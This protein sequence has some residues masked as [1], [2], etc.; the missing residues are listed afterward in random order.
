[1]RTSSRDRRATRQDKLARRWQPWQEPKPP[2][3]PIPT[4]KKMG[5]NPRQG[6]P[7]DS[8]QC[9]KLEPSQVCPD[10]GLTE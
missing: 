9:D 3:D 1:M 6:R 8:R 10:K 7:I 4:G 5:R 2:G